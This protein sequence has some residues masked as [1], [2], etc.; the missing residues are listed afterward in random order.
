VKPIRRKEK[1]LQY[2]AEKYEKEETSLVPYVIFVG[3]IGI[4][5]RRYEDKKCLLSK[6][7]V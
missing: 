4:F 6:A 2:F 5:I 3:K 1:F 7:R